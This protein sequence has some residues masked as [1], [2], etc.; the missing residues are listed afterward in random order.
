MA[1]GGR[2]HL[3]LVKGFDQKH[4]KSASV[5]NK[6]VTNIHNIDIYNHICI[7]IYFFNILYICI[8]V[9]LPPFPVTASR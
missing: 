7:D 6:I 3:I 5:C 9:G 1:F 2:T 8:Y 4:P